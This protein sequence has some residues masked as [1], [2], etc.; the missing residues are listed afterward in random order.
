MISQP[1]KIRCSGEKRN[2]PD[3]NKQKTADQH[4]VYNYATRN[5]TSCVKRQ[6]IN[7]VYIITP[8]TSLLSREFLNIS[9]E[10]NNIY[11]VGTVVGNDF[12]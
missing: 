7:T 3:R 2:K 6:L 5:Y 4:G 8:H 12:T 11:S 10:K 1:H 9:G